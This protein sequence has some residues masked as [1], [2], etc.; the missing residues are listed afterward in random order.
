MQAQQNWSCCAI[1]EFKSIASRDLNEFFK[2]YAS[3][4]SR[5]GYNYR[6]VLFTDAERNGHGDWFMKA[7]KPYGHVSR[8]RAAPNPIHDDQPVRAYLWHPTKAFIS[9]VLPKLL[10]NPIQDG[11]KKAPTEA[12]QF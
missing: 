8:C 3:R 9:E 2:L 4:Q 6:L 5:V 1:L 10:A 12:Y 11:K 7:L